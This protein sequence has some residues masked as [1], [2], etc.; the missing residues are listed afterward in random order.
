M[1]VDAFGI[2]KEFLRDLLKEVSAGHA[3]LP[4]F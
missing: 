1:G 4:E 2:E 3:Q